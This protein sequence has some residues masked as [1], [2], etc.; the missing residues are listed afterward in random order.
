MNLLFW[1]KPKQP[2]HK[3]DQRMIYVFTW[4]GQ[5]YFKL[6]EDV[7][8]GIERLGVLEEYK[9]WM[10]QGMSG[11]MFNEYLDALEKA[12][13]EYVADPKKANPGKA[14][15]IIYDMRKHKGMLT[16]ADVYYNYLA[17]FYF[18]EEEEVSQFIQRIQDEKCNAFKEAAK[19]SNS[20][21]FRLPELGRLIKFMDFTSEKWEEFLKASSLLENQHNEKMKFYSQTKSGR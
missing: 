18:T 12:N 10:A 20:F 19:D 7:F 5:H 3:K 2:Q 15:A 9:M 21:F 13:F 17:L 11:K 8:I 1:R 14:N 6:P 4:K 16:V